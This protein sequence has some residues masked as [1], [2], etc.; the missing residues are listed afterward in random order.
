M[1]P[2][3]R[4][5]YNVLAMEN[6]PSLRLAAA[7][8]ILL[9]V[10]TCVR[11]Q[12]SRPRSVGEKP[13][14]GK[15]AAPVP[16]PT[17]TA[18]P[19]PED[20]LATIKLE[21]TIVTIPVTVLDRNGR[22]VPQ[23]KKGDFRLFED[24]QEQEIEEFTTVEM[25]FHVV[26]ML[27]TSHSAQ[28]RLDEI[29]QAAIAFVEQLRPEDRV[30]VVSFDDR[31]DLI[32]DFTSDRAQLYR[33]IRATRTG[34]GTKLYDA[35]DGVM[36]E[37]LK[38]IQDRKAIVLFTDGADTS[39]RNADGPRT[40]ERV[41]S[42]EVLVYPV[43]YYSEGALRVPSL[44]EEAPGPRAADPTSP[45]D[46]AA[47]YRAARREHALDYG[48]TSRYL[49]QLAVS[50]GGRFHQAET[51]GN[52]NQAFAQIAEDLRSQ[53]ALSYSPTNPARDGSFRRVRIRVDRPDVLVRTR[54]GYRAANGDGS[55]DGRTPK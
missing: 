51:I 47:I 39:S 2:A 1:S 40:I 41:K 36:A 6:H 45:F 42:S 44:A 21:T 3:G 22:Y 43:Q 10:P 11:A 19:S 52:L 4:F 8:V 18:A 7:L 25:P 35:L 24:N 48:P 20:D 16:P 38:G 50:S 9:G 31:I 15:K 46:P 54:E 17:P 28:F 29:Q 33:A 13:P 55:S 49:R 26:L 53:Y 14:P 37:R 23:M 30:C 34:A 27:D 12:A 32:A 5:R